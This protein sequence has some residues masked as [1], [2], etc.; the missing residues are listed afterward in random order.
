[1]AL[2]GGCLCGEL[3]QVFEP[4][5]G[6]VDSRAAWNELPEDGLPRYPGA[7]ADA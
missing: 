1:M 3:L 6:A 7:N 2:A 5:G 4:E